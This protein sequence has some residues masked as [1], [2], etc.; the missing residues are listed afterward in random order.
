MVIVCEISHPMSWHL[1]LFTMWNDLKSQV[2][3]Y[4]VKDS[5]GTT[6]IMCILNEC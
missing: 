5:S 6:T 2:T 4:S 1:C 3:D